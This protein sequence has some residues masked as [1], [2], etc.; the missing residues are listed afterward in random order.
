MKLHEDSPHHG[1][2]ARTVNEW[3]SKAGLYPCPCCGYLV[4]EEGPGSY[5]ICPVCGWEDDLVQLRFPEMGGANRPLIACQAA[6]ASW[7]EREGHPLS[8]EE[9][10]FIQDPSWRPLDPAVDNVERPVS[11]VAY[12]ATYPDDRTVYYYW[13]HQRH[14]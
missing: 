12:G 5:D 8:P 9:G 10:G 13:R 11:G 14:P 3:V 1:R 2:S 6:Y 7:R 4:F